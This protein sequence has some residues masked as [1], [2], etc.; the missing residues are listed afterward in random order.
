LERINLYEVEDEEIE[1]L[2]R[3]LG[4]YVVDEFEGESF[5][6]EYIIGIYV[7]NTKQFN[8]PIAAVDEPTKE[9]NL[10]TKEEPKV[11]LISANLSHQEEASIIAVLSDYPDGFA[12]SYEHMLGLD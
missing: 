2:E 7:D 5:D 8:E 1:G 4:V 12:W 3:D 9:V 6:E 11:V 10:G